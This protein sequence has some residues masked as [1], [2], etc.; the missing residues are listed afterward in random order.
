MMEEKELLN[1]CIDSFLKKKSW[2]MMQV[3]KE[4]DS[5]L[6]FEIKHENYFS[7]I[8]FLAAWLLKK[9]YRVKVKGD[10]KE[11][12]RNVS[13]EVCMFFSQMSRE[14]YRSVLRNCAKD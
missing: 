1:F 11:R 2:C 6:I 12:K 3:K 7:P 8:L 4:K 9:P 14:V 5:F 10:V 13:G